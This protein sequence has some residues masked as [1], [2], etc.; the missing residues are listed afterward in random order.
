MPMVNISEIL[1]DF[2]VAVSVV[3]PLHMKGLYCISECVSINNNN[4]GPV[5]LGLLGK[6]IR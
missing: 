1:L 4:I 3:V 6:L 2:L 5:I